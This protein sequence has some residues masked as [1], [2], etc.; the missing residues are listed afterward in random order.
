[1]KYK[2]TYTTTALD[3][4]QLAMY[5]TYGSLIGVCNIIFTVAMLLLTGKFWGD[6]GIPMK[7]LLIIGICL[8]TV[9]QPLAIYR[10]AKKQ[11]PEI[12]QEVEIGF[13]DHGVHIKTGDQNSKLKWKAIQGVSKKPT[14]IIIFSTQKHGFVLNNK[15]L[16]KEK[17][18]CYE[19]ILSKTNN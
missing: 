1:M 6:V 10:R 8:F 4:W 13:D 3:V 18:A 16:G 7:I 5:G 14:M 2:F 11:I 9:I 12:P 17:R 19:Y 15:V